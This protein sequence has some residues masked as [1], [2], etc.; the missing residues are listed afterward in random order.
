MNNNFNYSSIGGNNFGTGKFNAANF[1]GGNINVTSS[2]YTAPNMEPFPWFTPS[3]RSQQYMSDPGA[4]NPVAS[5]DGG[6]PGQNQ[7]VPRGYHPMPQDPPAYSGQNQPGPMGYNTSVA[8]S[9]PGAPGQGHQT[10]WDSLPGHNGGYGTL[11]Q[12][13]VYATAPSQ[14]PLGAMPPAQPFT[15]SAG[16][17]QPQPGRGQSSHVAYAGSSASLHTVIPATHY[18]V[19][20][21]RVPDATRHDWPYSPP[22]SRGQRPQPPPVGPAPFFAPS[23]LPAHPASAPLFGPSVLRP[24]S[25]VEPFNSVGSGLEGSPI[26]IT[27]VSRGRKHKRSQTMTA[28]ELAAE[29]ERM[30][31]VK[32]Q[33][34]SDGQ[35]A[36]RQGIPGLSKAPAIAGPSVMAP[37]VVAT[38]VIA[39]PTPPREEE[40][41][42][43]PA[44]ALANLADTFPHTQAEQEVAIP[45]TLA[46]GQPTAVTQSE[47]AFADVDVA[48]IDVN[49]LIND[50]EYVLPPFPPVGAPMAAAA[51][52]TDAPATDPTASLTDEEIQWTLQEISHHLGPQVAVDQPVPAHPVELRDIQNVDRG[53]YDAAMTSYQ[54]DI[55]SIGTRFAAYRAGHEPVIGVDTLDSC[56]LVADD[57][58]NNSDSDVAA[59]ADIIPAAESSDPDASQRVD[60]P[61]TSAEAVASTLPSSVMPFSPATLQMSAFFDYERDDMFNP[62]EENDDTFFDIHP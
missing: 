56:Q 42:L 11:G 33:R 1:N 35:S 14:T 45:A 20:N 38:A 13:Q 58:N 40:T 34:L 60:T 16:T 2:L 27:R 30:Q 7:F 4:Y 39:S 46:A 22:R 28:E 12:Q 43:A 54:T 47:I 29:R 19:Q 8:G 53:G 32:R 6:P 55:A 48:A 10:P 9:Y 41:M 37:A 44:L 49:V 31:R 17:Y 5:T 23:V 57:S 3:A 15:Y 51:E 24:P 62:H 52:E 50:P 61:S 21:R 18:A 59:P 36:A 26:E 25:A